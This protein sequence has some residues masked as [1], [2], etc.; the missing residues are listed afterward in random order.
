[1]LSQLPVS[2]RQCGCFTRSESTSPH[3]VLMQDHSPQLSPGRDPN[4]LIN[5]QPVLK[6]STRF[7][8][9]ATANPS[10][11]PITALSLFRLPD[12]FGN[13]AKETNSLQFCS[14]WCLG[15]LKPPCARR[16]GALA[17][18]SLHGPSLQSRL[19]FGFPADPRGLPL[20]ACMQP[21]GWTER[22]GTHPLALLRPWILAENPKRAKWGAHTHPLPPAAGGSCRS[23]VVCTIFRFA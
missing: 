19:E 1:M 9:S 2:R 22:P 13:L 23:S 7:L 4:L 8:L 10:S 6:Y 14:N 3:H 15:P 18:A 12:R 16:W 21:A 17:P 11:S 5:D 20:V